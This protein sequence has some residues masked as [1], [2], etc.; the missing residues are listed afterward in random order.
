[1]KPNKQKVIE[2][3]NKMEAIVGST[4]GAEGKTVIIS[5]TLGMLP[6]VTKDGVTVA[7]EIEFEDKYENIGAQ[8]LRRASVDSDN[9][10]KDGTT[11]TIILANEIINKGTELTESGVSH[12]ILKQGIEEAFL[13][14]SQKLTELSADVT[15]KE[16]FNLAKVS[17]NNDEV[18]AKLISEAYKNIGFEGVIDVVESSDSESSV[19]VI[20][21]MRIDKGY[22][23]P[24]LVTKP[25]G[26]TSELENCAVFLIDGEVNDIKEIVDTVAQAADNGASLLIVAD[27][28]CNDVM[29][30]LIDNKMKGALK[31]NVVKTPNIGGKRK[32]V[33][34]DLAY[35]TGAEIWNKELDT[36]FQLGFASKVIST[37]SETIV[38]QDEKPEAL[39]ERIQFLKETKADDKRISNLANA[40]AV[41]S[42]GANNEAEMRE[43]K[44]RVDDAVGAVKSSFGEGFVPGAGSTLAYISTQMK[45]SENEGYNLMR[46]CIKK[47]QKKLLENANLGEYETEKFGVGYNLKKREVVDLIYDGIIDSTKVVRTSLENAKSV[48]VLVLTTEHIL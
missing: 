13:D 18:I 46:E 1:M 11:G 43:I 12:V 21:G 28:V 19:A 42:V 5:N 48:A 15:Q 36:E 38:L 39:E 2:G 7:K 20:D 23:S 6:T 3:I 44:D 37:E 22:I 25:K 16:I 9:K 29:N 40:V 24:Y 8:I 31:I 41:I 10:V 30:T 45:N 4:Y 32:E 17:A 26:M 47:P 34:E 35:Y 27:N 33:L 14:I